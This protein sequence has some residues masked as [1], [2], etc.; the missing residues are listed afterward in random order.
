MKTNCAIDLGHRHLRAV[1]A[2]V[3][4]GRVV[5]LRTVDV[6]LPE[7]LDAQDH[8]ARGAFVAQ[9]L[10]SAGIAAERAVWTLFRER[11]AFKR[12]VLPTAEAHELPGMVRLA[13]QRE[14]SLAPEAIIDFIPAPEG[15]FWAVAV[16]PAEV[17]AIRATAAAAGIAVERIT[18]RTFGT[19]MLLET[20]PLRDGADP[21]ACT[22]ALDL[23]GD[24]VEL[25]VAA[26]NGLHATRG[27]A[28][29]SAA[30]AASVP[31]ARRSWTGFRL[32]QPQLQPVAIVAVGAEPTA[33]LV[34]E[35]LRG[36]ASIDVSVLES[37]PDITAAASGALG[38]CWPLAGL[39]L[40]PARRKDRIDLA[41]PRRAPDLA[42]RRRMRAYLVVAVL[43][44]AY[45]VGWTIGKADRGAIEGRRVDL[46]TKAE[47]AMGEHQRF[48][49]DEMRVRHLDAWTASQPAWLDSMLYLSGFA[50]DPARVVLDSW[51]G[52]ALEGEVTA[53]KDGSMRF[54]PAVRIAMDAETS[55]RATADALREALVAK[56]EFVV[57]STSTEGKVGHRLPVAVEMVIE[58]V[59][60]APV[61]RPANATVS[62]RGGRR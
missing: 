35:A 5:V 37:H 55:D 39:L 15:G 42:A 43:G 2:S 25:V 26:R 31:E 20:L 59:D 48:R 7:T 62:Q 33:A 10:R 28:L 56:R 16:A 14:T 58:S 29:A 9:S 38:T 12:L 13:M 40:E 24:G 52:Q 1:E 54:S 34:A 61:E 51:S 8:A 47:K 60:G 45:A 18:P 17:A 30:P 27:I 44:I 22:A 53:A 11:A 57:R 50:P 6:A 49:R 23:S 46:V 41:N 19:A 36:D 32:Q 21:Q 3:E 4:R